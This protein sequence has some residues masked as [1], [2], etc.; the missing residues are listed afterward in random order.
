MNEETLNAENSATKAP[1]ARR[2]IDAARAAR[3]SAYAPYS[4]YLV[5]AVVIV[6]AVLSFFGLR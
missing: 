2:L 5:G 1:D 4:N 3:E 6:I